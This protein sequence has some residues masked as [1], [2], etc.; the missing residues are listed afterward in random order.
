MK[1]LI[2]LVFF[3]LIP[4]NLFSQI[5]PVTNQ[6]VLNPLAINPAFAGSRGALNIAAFYRKQWIG[7]AGSPET[8]TFSADA[9]FMDRK[10]G[11][12]LIVSN[13]KIGATKETHFSTSYS[14]KI[15]MGKSI[16]SFGFGAGLVATNT[17]YSDLIVLDPGDDYYLTDSHVFIVP[18]FSFG[19][20]YSIK[21][22]FAGLSIP[23]LLKYDFNFSK[24]KYTMAVNPG[25]SSYL[26]NTGYVFTIN[27]KFKIYPSTLLTYAP[28]EKLLY[29]LNAHFNLFDKVWTGFSYRSN[30]SIIGLLQFS[31]LD[32]LK[33]AYTY[34]FEF[35]RLGTYSKGSHEIMLRYEFKY[36]VNVVNPLIF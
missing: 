5:S 31:V 21:N 36:K 20:Y 2:R 26:F 19:V 1:K 11:L 3:S 6:Y 35:G 7:I 8:M 4:L 14:Y 34:D 23:K 13:D 15:E 27:S 9:A 32:Q 10:L 18:E 29:D 33:I 24:N 17:K 22:Y 16:L 12:G 30:K 28:G 25:L